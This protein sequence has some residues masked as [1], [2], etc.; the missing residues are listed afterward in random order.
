[1]LTIIMMTT[2]K[3]NGDQPG[4]NEALCI[5]SDRDRANSRAIIFPLKLTEKRRNY[6][7]KK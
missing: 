5:I 1:M 7:V 3:I 4:H 6:N 2:I